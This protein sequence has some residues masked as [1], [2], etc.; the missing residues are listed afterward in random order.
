MYQIG[1]LIIFGNKGVC[2]VE[3]VGFL[4]EADNNKLYYTLVP[5]LSNSGKIYTP[6]DNDKVIMRPLLTKEEAFNLIDDI[7]NIETLWVPN[8]KGRENEYKEAIKKCDC[9]ELI[10]II[11]TIY[12]RK[13]ARLTNGKKVLAIDNKYYKIA[14]DNLYGELSIALNISMDEVKEL[15]LNKIKKK[16]ILSKDKAFI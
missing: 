8:E 7:N 5:Y 12:L 3:S 11:K 15:I 6:V 13:Q 9:R 14:E 10:K 1:D 16:N 2:R 4:E